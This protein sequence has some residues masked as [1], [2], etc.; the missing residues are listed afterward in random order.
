MDFLRKDVNGQ[1]GG[2]ESGSTLLN[3]TRSD[4]QNSFATW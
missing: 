4:G 2:D 3:P 1:I